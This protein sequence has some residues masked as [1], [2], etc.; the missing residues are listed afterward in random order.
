MDKI[1]YRNLSKSEIIGRCGGNEKNRMTTQNQQ[2]SNA[3][4]NIKIPHDIL[5]I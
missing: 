5:P 2:K 4:N 1:W 3:K